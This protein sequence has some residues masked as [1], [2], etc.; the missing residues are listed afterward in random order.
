MFALFR[1]RER[2]RPC[3]EVGSSCGS[4]LVCQ[5]TETGWP[6]A[7]RQISP[8]TAGITIYTTYYIYTYHNSTH[9]SL[10]LPELTVENV[11]TEQLTKLENVSTAK[12]P[13]VCVRY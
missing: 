11:N 4:E 13:V 8:Q 7:E 12:L 3:I 5:V 2:N 6:T 10:R 1:D 9:F